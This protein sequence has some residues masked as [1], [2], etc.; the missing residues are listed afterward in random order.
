VRDA[1]ALRA[2]RNICALVTTTH[3]WGAA[4][5]GV[6]IRPILWSDSFKFGF[7]SPGQK[8]GYVSLH[9]AIEGYESVA[10]MRK[11]RFHPD[12]PFD[13]LRNL[14]PQVD[15]QLLTRLLVAW[16][17]FYLQRKQ[18]NFYRSLFRSM[19]VA[20]HAGLFPSDGLT[21]MSDAG[22]RL[23]LWVSAFEVLFHSG[24]KKGW[25]D[26]LAVQTAM[27]A[28]PW[29]YAKVIRKRYKV[30]RP[31]RKVSLVEKIYEE[32]NNA[33]NDFLHGNPVSALTLRFGRRG[34]RPSLVT[35]A[36]ALY[37]GAL[38]AFLHGKVPGGPD[39]ELPEG[40]SSV[41]AAILY[42]E[43]HDGLSNV[44]RALEKATQ[45]EDDE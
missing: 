10:R 20:F 24:G 12:V 38:L 29:D 11:M 35:L 5:D 8:D 21:G 39:E 13:G 18:R 22:L 2:F 23:A 25:S 43:R 32:L 40:T 34:N 9:G 1:D 31:A 42:M 19:D 28:G 14:K 17:R 27:A 7:Y 33:R 26:K 37:H 41:E 30:T 44:Q 6:A 16:R 36:P 3:G 4:L 15:K 45:T